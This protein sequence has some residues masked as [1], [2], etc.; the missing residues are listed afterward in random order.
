PRNLAG[1]PPPPAPGHPPLISI[2]ELHY[3]EYD[4]P[5]DLVEDLT[6]PIITLL[7][8]AVMELHQRSSFRDPGAAAYDEVDG[9]DVEV[10]VEGAADVDTCCIT[11]PTAPFLVTYT[12]TDRAGNRATPEIRNVA[13]VPACV[14]PSFLCEDLVGVVCAVCTDSETC[15]CF[16]TNLGGDP[17]GATVEEYVPPK[18]VSPPVLT[19]RGDGTLAQTPS[20]VVVMLHEV[21]L[22]H[23]FME[24]GVD[25]HDDVDGDLTSRVSA[26]GTAAVDTSTVTPP[27]EPF[28][29]RYS[30]SDAAGNAAAEVRRRVAVVDPC[31]GAGEALCGYSEADGTAQCSTG[32]FCLTASAGGLG[33]TAEEE[34]PPPEPPVLR[35]AGPSTLQLPQGTTYASCPKEGSLDQ[36]C[37]RGVT[38]SDAA[39]G[40]LTSRVLA[41]STDGRT[42]LFANRG[43]SGCTLDTAIP[44]VYVIDFSVQNSLGMTGCAQRTIT[45][46]PAC[47]PGEEL[48]L[49]GL[50]C[51][52]AGVCVD[53]LFGGAEEATTK[54]DEPPTIDLRSTAAVTSAYVEVKQHQP[55]EACTALELEANRSDTLCEPGAVA[56]DAEDGDLTARVLA[57][58]PLSCRAAGCPGHEF[59]SKGLA[60]CVNMSADVGTVFDVEF[61]VFDF[62]VPCQSASVTRS[63]F[64]IQPCDTGEQLCSDLSCS[65]IDCAMRDTLLGAG[66]V[67]DTT[68]PTITF[69]G[70]ST[71]SLRYADSAAAAALAPCTAA[72]V[73]STAASSGCYA[74][75]LDDMDGDVSTSLSVQQDRA[76]RDC[77]SDACPFSRMHECFPGTYGF[78]F[79]AEDGSRNRAVLRL[80]VA[81]EEQAQIAGEIRMASSSKNM[82]AVLTQAASLLSL[83]SAEN[84]AV[85][86][87]LLETVNA[88]SVPGEESEL[89]DVAITD[90]TVVDWSGAVIE[91]V[92]TSANA[93]GEFQLS[94]SFTIDQAV[95][96]DVESNGRGRRRLSQ[97]DG[98][99]QVDDAAAA[100]VSAAENG[101]LSASIASAA[102]DL[103][104]DMATEVTEAA[105]MATASLT[106]EVDVAGAYITAISEEIS[107][108]QQRGNDM[109]VEL[110]R[111]HAAT[112]ESVVGMNSTETVERI[113]A[114]WLELQQLDFDNIESLG[115]T[116]DAIL[117][118]FMLLRAAF[119]LVQTGLVN[120]QIALQDMTDAA[121][122]VTEDTRAELESGFEAIKVARAETGCDYPSG[123]SVQDLA[124]AAELK[125]TFSVDPAS[126]GRR[127]LL[128][129]AGNAQDFVDTK[130]TDQVLDVEY[131]RYGSWEMPPGKTPDFLSPSPEAAQARYLRGCARNRLVGGLF[132]YLTRGEQVHECSQRFAPLEAPCVRGAH[133]HRYGVDPVFVP[134]SSLF[135]SDLQDEVATFYDTSAESLQ[136]SHNSQ[137]P[138]P[139]APRTLP[140]HRGGQPFFIDA[141]LEAHRA[142]QIYTFLDEGFVMDELAQSVETTMTTFNSLKQVWS[143]VTLNWTREGGHWNLRSSVLIAPVTYWARATLHGILWL[144]LHI[145]WVG[146]SIWMLAGELRNLFP[147]RLKMRYCSLTYGEALWQH[148]KSLERSIPFWGAAMQMATVL[149]GVVYEI[150]MH[151]FSAEGS[152]G[153]YHDLHWAANYFLSA[154]HEQE[155]STEGA[156]GLGGPEGADGALPAWAWKEDNGGLEAYEQQGRCMRTLA[157]LAFAFFQMQAIR[158][159]TMILRLLMSVEYQ[160]RLSVITK[161]CRASLVEVLQCVPILGL[162][163]GWAMLMHI[164]LG[165]RQQRFSTY[166]QSLDQ[167]ALV[168]LMGDWQKLSMTATWEPIHMDNL[169]EKLYKTFFGII[170]QLLISNF[171][172]AIICQQLLK[173]WEES[174]SAPTLM[175]DL[176]RFYRNRMNVR[177][178]KKWPRIEHTCNLL[179][180]NL[181]GLSHNET[182][183]RTRAPRVSLALLLSGNKMPNT[184][185]DHDRC[186]HVADLSMS[187]KLLTKIL[188]MCYHEW[189]DRRNALKRHAM[190]RKDT[191]VKQMVRSSLN[192]A[193]TPPA[194]NGYI[195]DPADLE[196]ALQALQ[197]PTRAVGANLSHKLKNLIQVEELFHEAAREIVWKFGHET[198]EGN[199]KSTAATTM[200]GSSCG[201]PRCSSKTRAKGKVAQRSGQRH[202]WG[203]LD[204]PIPEIAQLQ[205]SL[206]ERTRRVKSLETAYEQFRV[207]SKVAPWSKATR[208]SS[209]LRLHVAVSREGVRDLP[210]GGSPALAVVAPAEV[211]FPGEAPA[212]SV[213]LESSVG[214]GMAVTELVEPGFGPRGSAELQDQSSGALEMEP[215]RASCSMS[216]TQAMSSMSNEDPGEIPSAVGDEGRLSS[217]EHCVGSKLLE[218]DIP[219][220]RSA[221]E[222]EEG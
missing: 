35:L 158:I 29:I 1:P 148:F 8:A 165:C 55:Y 157:L 127:Q 16:E 190:L 25:A 219:G 197:P 168:G 69:L 92:I 126:G 135:R 122:A 172:L 208:D 221:E 222:E 115:L 89:S 44:G 213:V 28:T 95:A 141:A 110:T 56:E 75:A 97:Q 181:H 102:L 30:V 150:R 121:N 123:E 70:P 152:F 53:D 71:V 68:P 199:R 81:V 183:R 80:R 91:G 202:M 185:A 151:E 86:Q 63:I 144:L 43:V 76:C 113:L 93:T 198:Q 216:P 87:G 108:L 192:V 137:T 139:F 184:A 19:L 162:V 160:Q 176:R 118:K 161:T 104:A 98:I 194:I 54:P 138:M 39:D 117:T 41:C 116:A 48:C 171:I 27:D 140:G 201:S 147:S 26:F 103:G 99:S 33:A 177:V 167:H 47:G 3:E 74:E 60:G 125:Y 215:V 90:V 142:R 31:A 32:G 164:E 64:I 187:A 42:N 61:L 145:V 163:A 136:L 114:T 18:D 193:M 174:K 206:Q 85:R 46:A 182:A 5:A 149:M 38:A 175:Q 21:L 7:G 12:A 124:A 128:A 209:A 11:D 173:H 159:A 79:A 134:G 111:T 200:E 50:A 132:F 78:L 83:D 17:T 207:A 6:P 119:A 40:D 20:G 191:N 15:M 36:V 100:V 189:T 34:V 23:E 2:T 107:Q 62:A 212:E 186:I 178:L 22:Q 10:H 96:V 146:V 155:T 24:P 214:E 72:V 49:S 45:V 179:S 14:H 205:R 51:S 195:H 220:G 57:C 67:Q 66:D 112:L 4:P 37:D 101:Q 94:V 105:N 211:A 13:V 218:E 58:P 143:V 188:V 204:L 65:S 131:P 203:S 109:A 133:S 52:V 120:A 210:R 59:L 130:G 129:R 153:V 154:R 166:R 82:T 156:E 196:R 106:P 217:G 9:Y 180:T 73:N 169:K 84:T 88:D 170:S 77:S